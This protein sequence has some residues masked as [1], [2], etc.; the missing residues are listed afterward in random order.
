MNTASRTLWLA[1]A[2]WLLAGGGTASAA[3]RP[4]SAQQELE[5]KLFSGQLAD[6]ARSAKTK[7]EAAEML[8]SRPY[9]EAAEALRKFLSDASNHP[10]QVAVAEAVAKK[11]GGSPTFVEP[12]LAMLTGVEPL[13]RGPAARALVTYKNHGAIEKL[14]AIAKDAKADKAVRIVTISALQRV[15]DKQAVDALVRLVSDRD[16]AIRAAA[17]EALAMLTNIRA[18]G[19]SPDRWRR[20]WAESKNKPASAW[21]A[22]LAENLAREKAR[23]EDENAK[24]RQRLATAMMDVYEATAAA[25][26]GKLL[27]SALK[28]PLPDVRLVGVTLANRKVATNGGADAELRTQVRTMLADEDPRV[29]QAAALLE[30]NV[31][32]PNAV[33]ELLGRLKI[34]EVPK[35]KQGLLT[36]LGQLRDPKTIGPILAEVL[37]K[38]EPVAAAAAEALARG[39]AT[40]PLVGKMRDEAVRT[41]LVRYGKGANPAP[42][43]AL[44]EAILTAMGTV[45]DKKFVPTL[46]SGLKGIEATVRLAAVKSLAQLRQPD[47]ADTLAPLAADADRGVRQAV[48]DALGTLGGRKHL[49][50]ILQRTDPTAEPDPTVREKAWAVVTAALGKA[51]AATLSDVCES[52]A[53][54]TDAV[55]QRI[56][57]RQMLVTALQASGSRELPAAQRKLAA[58]LSSASRPAEA[59]PLL[60]EAYRAYAAA[61][62]PQADAVYLEWIDALLKANDPVVVKAMGDSARTESFPQVLERLNKRLRALV[63][64][65]RHAPAILIGTE[66]V[67]QLAKRL[68]PAQRQAIEAVVAGASA[69]QLAVDRDRVAKLAAQLLAADAAVGKAAAAE[70]KGMGDRAVAPLVLELKKVAAAEK[71]NEQAEK[72]ILDVLMQIA[73]KLTGYDPRAPKDERLQRIDTWLKVL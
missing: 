20:W 38:D 26:K 4:L 62:N 45:A 65:G 59:G 34:E 22:D 63:A 40:Q 11:G 41:L 70:L 1:W 14:I 66:V 10:A 50:I 36:A 28:D 30:A 68:T 15:L 44:R 53:D 3:P 43:A 7:A 25:Q 39:A 37:S 67:R 9:P 6:A 31:G 19:T 21:L 32:D 17:G 72:A 55:S 42:G 60:G 54:R 13:V 48:L 35:V 51:D 57:L 46:K 27:L 33:G 24:L 12:L 23:L 8:L 73:P 71:L 69:K 58:A 29:R 5:L 2:C 56:Q 52:L 47:L 16:T 61:K 49:Q 64:E 18:F